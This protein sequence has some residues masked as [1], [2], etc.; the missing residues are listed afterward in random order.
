MTSQQQQLWKN[1]QDVALLTSIGRVCAVNNQAISLLLRQRFSDSWH[2]LNKELESTVAE[3]DEDEDDDDFDEDD[4]D[5]EDLEEDQDHLVWAHLRRVAPG[6]S[7]SKL[8]SMQLKH[9]PYMETNKTDPDT[10]TSSGV[11][12]S[13][14][15]FLLHPLLDQLAFLSSSSTSSA[16]STAILRLM[17]NT[18]LS[19]LEYH[20][21]LCCSL[22]AM[23]AIVR[24]D[25][26]AADASSSHHYYYQT[27]P[28]ASTSQDQ[29]QEQ[30]QEQTLIPVDA[31]TEQ[32]S[33]YTIAAES[34]R[35]AEDLL[36][37]TYRHHFSSSFSTTT[38]NDDITWILLKLALCNNQV[39]IFAQAFFYDPTA[40]AMNANRMKLPLHVLQQK[41]NDLACRTF[42]NKCHAAAASLLRTIQAFRHTLE[43]AQEH[44]D[45]D[46]DDLDEDMSDYEGELRQQSSRASKI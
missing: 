34:Y 42:T 1:P 30:D 4:F 24:Q 11:S 37:E 39:H 28:T 45:D 6:F 27:V 41:Y 22:L 3:E 17:H 40:M 25:A 19:V 14:Q 26:T 21:A 33:Y 38:T 15:A 32:Q 20:Y 5:E 44:D 29:D 18:A 2:I 7:P 13:N 46:D 23:H 35:C 31:E 10:T 8:F 43:W 16:V 12:F 36:D 9:V